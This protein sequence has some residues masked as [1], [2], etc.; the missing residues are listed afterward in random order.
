M[1]RGE[2][3]CVLCGIPK[4]R[5]DL[6]DKR[7]LGHTLFIRRRTCTVISIK[8]SARFSKGREKGQRTT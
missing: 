8:L 5:Y 6:N 7:R 2:D 4:M 1:K 3:S